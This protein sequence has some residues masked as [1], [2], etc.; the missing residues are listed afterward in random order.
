MDK[1]I[2]FLFVF[3]LVACI[4]VACY[5]VFKIM[6]IIIVLIAVGIGASF[7]KDGL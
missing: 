5:I 4:L 6:G 1:F 3:L 2:T 7:L